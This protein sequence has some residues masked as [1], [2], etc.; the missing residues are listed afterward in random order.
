MLPFADFTFPLL[1][2][3]LE[4]GY[5]YHIAHRL[6]DNAY[7]LQHFISLE[8]A[9]ATG[10][11]VFDITDR[12]TQHRLTNPRNGYK[13]YSMT[14]NIRNRCEMERMYSRAIQDKLPG[15]RIL[16]IELKN[17]LQHL[18]FQVTCAEGDYPMRL[19]DLPEPPYFYRISADDGR[20]LNCDDKYQKYLLS[21]IPPEKASDHYYYKYNRMLGW[22]PG[23]QV[24]VELL[25][26]D[27]P[28]AG[29]AQWD[30][31]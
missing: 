10:E 12:A 4:K 9:K 22:N 16:S 7:L 24:D 21:Y 8:E 18:Y 15:K 23:R 30:V 5:R 26:R 19:D 17:N 6:N 13:I 2:D 3:L 14:F 11:K 20:I 27:D 29:E 28:R 1:A 31:D 25:A